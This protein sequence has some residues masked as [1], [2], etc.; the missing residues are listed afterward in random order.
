M[1]VLNALLEKAR[2]LV[3]KQVFSAFGFFLADGP[4]IEDD[5]LKVWGGII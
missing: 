3:K 2:Y 5:Q 1:D 4:R